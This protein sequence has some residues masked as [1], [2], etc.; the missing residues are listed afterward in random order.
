MRSILI[1]RL[2]RLAI[3][4]GLLLQAVFISKLASADDVTTLDSA[5]LE[6]S[7]FDG[8]V[9]LYDAATQ[10]WMTTSMEWMDRAA[11]PASTFKVMSSLAAL[12]TGV[13]ETLDQRIT[14][15]QYTSSRDEINRELDFAAAF[16]LS[17]LPHYQ[18]LVRRIGSARM[19][20]YLD[21]V[22]YGNRDMGGGVDQFWISGDLAISPTQQIEFLRSLVEGSLPFRAQTM[23]Q[24][25][26]MMRRN[27]LNGS[28]HAK[29]GWATSSEGLH[30]GWSIGWVQRVAEEPL[31]FATLL[32]TDEPGDSFL[33]VRLGLA[34]D[35]IEQY[36]NQ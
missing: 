15:E 31:Y 7:G 29:T 25:R 2:Q 22:G 16:K 17:A 20:R 8:V 28:L 3:A 18:H 33:D 4:L 36:N 26:S 32:Q 9:V 12:E 35:T 21:A 6:S 23:A 24:V 19:Q 10:R 11:I 27:E 5:R 14:L 30:T 34:L 13:V 1:R